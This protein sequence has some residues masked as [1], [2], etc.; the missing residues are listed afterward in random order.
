MHFSIWEIKVQLNYQFNFYHFV[1]T[2]SCIKPVWWQKKWP[3]LLLKPMTHI[4]HQ[5]KENLF[6][7]RTP[8]T[9]PLWP[10]YSISLIKWKNRSHLFLRSFVVSQLNKIEKK[11][12]LSGKI[13]RNK[14]KT[15]DYWE[16]KKVMTWSSWNYE[17]SHPGQC[18]LPDTSLCKY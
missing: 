16:Q 14:L 9:D 10:I 13:K 1:V 3:P 11:K 8:I 7:K 18:M 15:S 2:F 5:E 12:R 6:I 17:Q 4:A